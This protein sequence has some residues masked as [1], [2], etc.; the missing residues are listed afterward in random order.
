MNGL[1][2]FLRLMAVGWTLARVDA[3]IPRELNPVLPPNI[4]LLGNLVRLFAGP[5]ARQ[6]RPGQRLAGA[7]EGMGPVAIKLGQFLSTRADIF[8]KEFADDLSHLKDRLPPFAHAAAVREVER[9]LDR[10]IG[11]LFSEF[12]PAVAAASLAQAHQA[13]LLDGRRVAVKVLRPDIE[14]RVAEEAASLTL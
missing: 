8:G 10:P 1:M 3:L 5:K 13:R 7:L 14:R 2:A 11:A 4:R 9:A 6:G 12:G